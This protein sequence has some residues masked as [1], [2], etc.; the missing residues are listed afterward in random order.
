MTDHTAAR[1]AL[2]AIETGLGKLPAGPW[3]VEGEQQVDLPYRHWEYALFT[4]NRD[5]LC[6][7]ENSDFGA[8]TREPPSGPDDDGGDYNYDSLHLMEHF[9]RCDPDTMRAILAYV[10]ALEAE[11]ESHATDYR[12]VR[13]EYRAVRDQLDGVSAENARLREALADA[14]PVSYTHLTLPTNREV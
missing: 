10:K 1:T 13:Q 4:P 14:I 9:S 3:K 6:G 11:R 2:A 8:V 12:R 7:T 5:R